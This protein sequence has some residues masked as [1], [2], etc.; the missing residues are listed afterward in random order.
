LFKFWPAKAMIFIDWWLV[1][2][3]WLY[4]WDW[5]WTLFSFCNYY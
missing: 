3:Q 1:F 5:H 4:Y 2:W